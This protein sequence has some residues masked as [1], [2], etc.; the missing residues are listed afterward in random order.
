VGIAEGLAAVRAEIAAAARRAGRDP[1]SVT[2]VAVSKSFPA[3]AVAAAAAAGAIDFGENRVQEA[4]LKIQ[5]LASVPGLRWHLIGR[6]Q[7]NKVRLLQGRFALFHALDRAELV[8]ALQRRLSAEGRRLPVLMEVNVGGEASKAGAATPDAALDLARRIA[9]ADALDLRGLMTV[10]PPVAEPEAARPFFAALRRLRD[11]LAADLG[12]PLPE[13]SMGMSGDYPVAV[14]EGATL[15][16]VGRAIFG[17]RP[18][19]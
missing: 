16:R 11:R 17:E 18:V 1:A 4:A 10:A 8:D 6:L 13:L 9:A 2:L 19:A 12:R 5:A 3:D 7:T 15:V 14:E